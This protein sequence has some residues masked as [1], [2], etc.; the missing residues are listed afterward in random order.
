MLQ[1]ICESFIARLGRG[2][3]QVEVVETGRADAGLRVLAHG[4]REKRAR[5]LFADA[6]DG[7]DAIVLL[8][9]LRS[10]RLR[11]VTI[12]LAIVAAMRA[13]PMTSLVRPGLISTSADAT[14]RTRSHATA[15]CSK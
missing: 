10:R 11:A 12:W 5:S 6:A 1:C 7:P 14:R 8:Q 2:Q 3:G 9:I 15:R 13:K 4:R